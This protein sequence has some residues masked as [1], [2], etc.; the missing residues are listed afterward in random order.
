MVNLQ[1][2]GRANKREDEEVNVEEFIA[3]KGMKA[4]GNR[5]TTYKLKSIDVLDPIPYEPEPVKEE[6]KEVEVE[7]TGENELEEPIIVEEDEEIEEPSSPP[8][9]SDDGGQ[10]SLF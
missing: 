10:A 2:D 1:Y 8:K 3:I 6:P 7:S 4:L 5:L 9:S